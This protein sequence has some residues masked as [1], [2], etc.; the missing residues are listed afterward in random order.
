MWMC[1]SQ[2]CRLQWTF[3]VFSCLE[4]ILASSGDKIHCLSL[5]SDHVLGW[6]NFS[7]TQKLG[8]IQSP[9]VRAPYFLG[10]SD[11]NVF[12]ISQS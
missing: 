12:I 2:R 3:V 1:G 8:L 6:A 4:S 10:H 7:L 5:F 11:S 9:P